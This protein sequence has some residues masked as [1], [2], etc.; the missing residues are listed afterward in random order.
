MEEFKEWIVKIGIP[1][2][3]GISMKLAIV[4]SKN[5]K[6]SWFDVSVSF[7]TG[8]A[9]VLLLSDIIMSSVPKEYVAACIA[10][11]AMSGEKVGLYVVYKFNVENFIKAFIS[12][13][14][15]GK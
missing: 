2:V 9:S 6:L 3:A 7:V 14:R 13:F 10:I 15:N 5:G 4:L 12:G 11:V 8:I 1:S